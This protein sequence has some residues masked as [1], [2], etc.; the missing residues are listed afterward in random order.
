MDLFPGPGI[1]LGMDI[2]LLLE[3][4]TGM[5]QLEDGLIEKLGLK[6]LVD[7]MNGFFSQ[8]ESPITMALKAFSS[9]LLKKEKKRSQRVVD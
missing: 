4:N 5:R 7:G 1:S 9:E 8:F 3:F 2:F 6:P